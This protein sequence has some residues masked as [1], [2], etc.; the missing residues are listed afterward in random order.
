M[1]RRYFLAQL[2][3]L[4]SLVSSVSA[5]NAYAAKKFLIIGIF[6]RRNI[7][8]TYHLFT[9]LAEYLSEV[10]Q[11]EVR[12]ETTKTFSAFWD[13]VK[14]KKYDLVHYNQY[15][16][17]VSHLHYGYDVILKNKE[18][19]KST[20]S[21]SLIVRKDSGFEKVSDLKGKVILFGGDKRAMQSYISATWLLKNGGLMKGDYKERFAI[22]PLNTIISTF[23][24]RADASGSGDVVMHLDNVK[25]RI[26]ISQL[27]FLAKTEPVPHLP[28]AVNTDLADKKISKIKRALI[29]LSETKEGNNILRNAKLDALVPATDAE[30]DMHR[31]IIT[32][33]YGSDY[34]LD[35]LKR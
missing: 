7:K 20:I 14:A 27:K 2:T 25:K 11:Q 4:V 16:Y 9:P 12:L 6:P 15:H 10:L 28:W 5:R 22:N 19:G 23:F 18:L 35:N 34:G 31:K 17:I 29:D 24:K 8:T 26:D 30:Y 33:V 21:G 3:S 32:D 13:A 1:N